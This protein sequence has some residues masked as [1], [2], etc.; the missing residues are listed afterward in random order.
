MIDE[1][2]R[3]LWSEV[4]IRAVYDL[5][6]Q[7]LREDYVYS[8]Y[9]RANARGWFLSASYDVGSFRWICDSLELNCSA[10]RREVFRSTQIADA[11]K[12]T[13]FAR[14]TPSTVPEL[15]VNEPRSAADVYI[16][17][18]GLMQRRQRRRAAR[19]SVEEAL[20][21]IPGVA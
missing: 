6:G 15:P 12:V 10:V 3:E 17:G 1:S 19:P 7:D 16:A 18:E 20:P 8:S 2:I 13:E 14:P 4:L 5:R 9:F 21:L 11:L